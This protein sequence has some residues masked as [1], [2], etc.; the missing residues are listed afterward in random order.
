[1]AL[2]LLLLFLFQGICVR[3][4]ILI[5][6]VQI[7]SHVCNASLSLNRFYC[8]VA[9]FAV[10][11][12]A[13]AAVAI[14]VALAHDDDDTTH[15]DLSLVTVFALEYLFLS[16]PNSAQ[17]RVRRENCC[18]GVAAAAA[19]DA[20][21]RSLDKNMWEI[22]PFPG[23]DR[24]GTGATRVPFEVDSRGNSSPSIHVPGRFL[25]LSLSVSLA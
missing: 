24:E 5:L 20:A 10:V 14:V 18:C 16:I 23:S 1:M 25:S 13:A 3:A 2:L 4:A 21:A 12:A 9:V 22:R 11:V 19:L 15:T 17:T 6:V 7:L 8:P